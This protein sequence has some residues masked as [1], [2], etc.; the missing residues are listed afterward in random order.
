M[1]SY[2][3]A[4]T[5]IYVP[6]F[7]GDAMSYHNGMKFSSVDRDN[8]L[9][10]GN[11]AGSGGPWWHNSCYHSALNKPFGTNLYWYPLT[12]QIAKTSIIMIRGA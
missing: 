6:L 1:P 11:C 2:M 3:F 10:G 4:Q 5:F 8:D 9:N 7:L 12:S